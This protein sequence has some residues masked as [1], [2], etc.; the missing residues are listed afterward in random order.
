MGLY[1]TVQY[2]LYYGTVHDSTAQTIVRSCVL[3][4][5]SSE[6]MESSG[7]FIYLSIASK[8]SPPLQ[9]MLINF[10]QKYI[11]YTCMYIFIFINLFI[12]LVLYYTSIWFQC[13]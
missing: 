10:Y 3:V 9:S 11:L 13:S 8:V 5:A 7:Q 2:R 1:I 12:Y 6:I 4:Q